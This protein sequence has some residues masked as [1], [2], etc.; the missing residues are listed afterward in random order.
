MQRFTITISP[1]GRLEDVDKGGGVR[2]V[3]ETLLTQV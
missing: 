1:A 2:F 3:G